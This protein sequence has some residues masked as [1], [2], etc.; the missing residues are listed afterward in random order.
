MTKIAIIGGGPAGCI[1]SIIAKRNNPDLDITIFEK[2]DIASTLL[3][4]GG[5][6]CN[7]SYQES[8]IKLFAQNYPRGEKFLYSVF[9]QF[10]VSDTR[11]FFNSIGIKT[12]VQKD[13]RIFPQ[14]DKS[15]D[16]IF[17]FKN[18]I[19]KLNIKTRNENVFSLK[20]MGEKFEVNDKIF[21]K[22]V[23]A[24]G[25]RSSELLNEVRNL[26]HNIV[27][28]K[29]ALSSLE[30]SEK[31]FSSISGVSL[32]EV[33]AIAYFEKK[34][35]TLKE[36]LLF[37]HK[38]I[39]GPL[40]YKVSSLFAKENYSEKSPIL[41]KLNFINDNDFNL[42]KILD[43]NSHKTIFNLISDFMPKSLAKLLLLEYKIVIEKKCHQ[44]NKEER[45]ILEKILLSLPITIT[46]PLKDGEI[47]TA[48]G[49][50]L[51]EISSKTMQSKLVEGLYFCGE[52][53][54]VDGFCGGF[55]LQNCWST[56]F[57]VGMNL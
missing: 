5:G 34:K 54:D 16:V 7:L 47:V 25:G 1:C 31:Y 15:L 21:D 42:Q 11:K 22:V 24:I 56:G 26:G 20:K 27:E 23:V 55:N 33:E 40:A 35:I 6:R 30:I 37:T 13:N 46:N 29:P 53:L 51:K 57:V 3:P 49:I 38:G 45:K 28:Q 10:F 17:A 52:I 4:T 41:L 36:D 9:N 12:Y 19:K 18:E 39:S 43:K 32:T 44:I 2:K 14:S 50:D 8:D 48:G